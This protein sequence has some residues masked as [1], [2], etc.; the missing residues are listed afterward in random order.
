MALASSSY[1]YVRHYPT[2]YIIAAPNPRTSCHILRRFHGCILL[3]LRRRAVSDLH[4]GP[5]RWFQ[6]LRAIL[7][8]AHL[9]HVRSRCVFNDW[10]EVL[11]HL[12]RHAAS[13]CNYYVLFLS[14]NKGINARGDW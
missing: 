14:G 5:R 11:H 7:L 10:L 13:R 8:F 9:Y 4:P 3:R 2:D 1:I 6:H 12:H